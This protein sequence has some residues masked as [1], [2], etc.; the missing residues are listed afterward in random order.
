MS[1]ED[2]R[3]LVAERQRYD[4]WLSALEARRAETSA[5]VFDR[6]HG[7]YVGRRTGVLEKLSA[8]VGSL[9]TL[10]EDLETR[11]DGLDTQ[12][13]AL[14][15]E[16]AEA[17]LR[18][19]V[20]EYDGERWDVVR[21]EVEASIGTLG[22]ERDAL[23]K[24]V[25]DVRTLLAS[26]RSAPAASEGEPV[27]AA[28]AVAEDL[29]TSETSLDAVADVDEPVTGNGGR[30]ATPTPLDLEAMGA[31]ESADDWASPVGRT[32]AG[33]PADASLTPAAPTPV[34]STPIFTPVVDY[35][36]PPA[37]PAELPPVVAPMSHP[38]ADR[39]APQ[40]AQRDGE[41]KAE[42][43]AQV[44]QDELDATEFDDA[45]ALFSTSA[46]PADAES[47]STGLGSLDMLD[48]IVPVPQE[49]DRQAARPRDGLGFAPAPEPGPDAGS[50]DATRDPF[51][52]LAFLRSV[53]DPATQ[54]SGVRNPTGTEPQKTLR[55]TECGT[56]NFPT[57][58]YCERCGGE[59]AAF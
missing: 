38:H 18:T 57:E 53:I 46:S 36:T 13:A 32:V 47:T 35:P 2:V 10:A 43:D 44:R 21:Q 39:D 37:T 48:G 34:S 25:E 9:S 23:L 29:P 27:P 49:P 6:V 16:R 45:L 33:L 15:D 24:E 31:P 56:M 41:R 7:D 55:C 42:R 30:T 20:G 52:D 51:D 17:M 54:G 12:L 1:I 59:L 14:E 50:G 5:R 19:A 40:E 11:I 3:T 26:A 4:D 28:Q 22:G 8:H 58:W